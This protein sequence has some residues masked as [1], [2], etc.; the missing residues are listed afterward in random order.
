[1]GIDNSTA[2]DY[3][4]RAGDALISMYKLA[5]SGGGYS[6]DAVTAPY[7]DLLDAAEATFREGMN[8]SDPEK[9]V[10]GWNQLTMVAGQIAHANARVGTV[11]LATA[12][13]HLQE[14]PEN[15][16]AQVLTEVDK[17]SS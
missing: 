6:G 12:V 1:M 10:E 2:D 3:D 8:T 4:R 11:L 15:V 17:H 16:V 7:A 13:N 5:K 14:S 9:I